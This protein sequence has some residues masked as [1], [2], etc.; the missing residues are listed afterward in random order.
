[1]TLHL[2]SSMVL[3]I[4]QALFL[5]LLAPF[6]VGV[7][8]L[9][10]TRMSGASI[11]LSGVFGPY[12]EIFKLLKRPRLA[13]LT[14]GFA[15]KAMPYLF[16]GIML[17]AACAIPVITIAS[18][19]PA[20]GDM[21]T[22]IYIFALA[23]F[24]FILSGLDTGS[25]FAMIGAAREGVL[26]VLVEPILFLGLWIAALVA[27]STQLGAIAQNVFDLPH[28]L[29]HHLWLP[30]VI[31]GLACAF[32]TAIESGAVPFDLAEAE[33]ELQ[34][35]PLT[36]YSGADF[37]IIKWGMNLKQIV[38]LQMFIGVFL[39]FGAATELTLPALAIAC[40]AAFG[41]L[42]IAS[43][44]IALLSNG[45]ARVRF[46]FANRITLTGFSLAFLALVSWL[47]IYPTWS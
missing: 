14:T 5:L 1:M 28:H 17:V 11:E 30:L 33:Q 20:I 46:I 34:E 23:R 3:G 9:I 25:P 47:V 38:V 18:P 26:G 4:V 10:T 19:M 35:G 39:P 6:F 22:L 40:V 44:L 7:A 29:E 21:I 32:A 45:A 42:L 36:E 8:G 16:F 43:I 13:P 31:G 27:G 15:F 24:I 37:G 41:K 2:H 12:H